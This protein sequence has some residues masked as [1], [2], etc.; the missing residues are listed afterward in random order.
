MPEQRPSFDLG[1]FLVLA[2]AGLFLAGL[3]LFDWRLAL[4]AGGWL[5]MILG[6]VRL[7]GKQ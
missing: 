1:D 3:Y 5:L 6:A 4:V 7:K 2:G